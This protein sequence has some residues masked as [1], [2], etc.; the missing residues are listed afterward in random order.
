MSAASSSIPA[1]RPCEVCGGL[2]FSTFMR[3]AEHD[4][5][6]CSRCGLERIDPQPTDET[7]AKIYGEHYYDAWGLQSDR[8][9]VEAIKRGTFERVLRGLGDLPRGAK[10]LDCGAA[11]GFLMQVAAGMGWEPFG[12]ELSEF[13]AGE[14]AKRFGKD[15]VHRGQLE[16]APWPDGTFDAITMCDYLEHVRDPE[17]ILRRALR[18]LKTGGK[19][20]I[21][22]PRVGSATYKAMGQRWTHYKVEHLYY[23][24]IE[25]LRQLLERM[26]FGDYSGATLFKTMNIRYMAHQFDV[27]PHPVLTPIVRSARSVVPGKIQRA[28]FPIAMGELVA[29]ATKR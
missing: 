18:L 15:H 13:G 4:F 12:A 27:Y 8:E 28:N 17:G 23:F 10:T 20:A 3:K 1:S 2:G 16:D 14:I 29:Y 22:M 9:S 21:T 7:L 5:T 25:N 24:S 19:I 26:G 11:T 6:R